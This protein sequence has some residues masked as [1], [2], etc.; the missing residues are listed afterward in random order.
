MKLGAVATLVVAAT[1][2]LLWMTGAV[3][4]RDVADMA[5]RAFGAVAILVV[6]GV[7]LGA[8]RG[9]RNAADSTDKPVP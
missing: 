2:A 4:G 6:A 3:P 1:L 7:L 8:L 9:D 5:P